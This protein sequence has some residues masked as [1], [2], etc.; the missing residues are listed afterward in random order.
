[1][2]K[3]YL[4]KYHSFLKFK[5]DFTR[6][7]IQKVKSYEVI[8]FWLKSRM[9]R[10][11]FLIL[12]GMLVGCTAGL[13]GVALKSLVHYIH[14]LISHKIHFEYQILF[15]I[16]FPFLGIVL[17]TAI[18]LTFFKDRTGKALALSFM[19][20]HRTPALSRQ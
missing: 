4:R 1:M 3:S 18:V 11:Q 7:S 15:Y 9:N 8:L 13:A 14:Y 20:S 12:S 2:R 10:T 5:R 16:I 17:T 19:K 6:Y